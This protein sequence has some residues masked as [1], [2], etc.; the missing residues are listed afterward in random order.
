MLRRV[1]NWASNCHCSLQGER[2]SKLRSLPILFLFQNKTKILGLVE[3]RSFTP[4]REWAGCPSVSSHYH[5]Q[6]SHLL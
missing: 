5:C 1:L 6:L 3:D 2:R 4:R